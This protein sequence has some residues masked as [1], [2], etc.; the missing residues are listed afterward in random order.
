[1]N[2]K[3]LM[4]HYVGPAELQSK[5]RVPRQAIPE[6]RN[7]AASFSIA[8]LQRIIGYLRDTDRVAKGTEYSG[9]SE[10]SLLRELVFKILH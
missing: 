4:V 5:L 6:F 7:A 8:K 1:M 9:M 10:A 2:A 3:V